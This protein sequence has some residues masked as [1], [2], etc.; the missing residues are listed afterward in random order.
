MQM[1]KPQ[2]QRLATIGFVLLL[3]GIMLD[4]LAIRVPVAALPLAFASLCAL[5]GSVVV[6]I[7]AMA[8]RQPSSNRIKAIAIGVIVFAAGF[9][10]MPLLTILHIW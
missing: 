5:L 1:N 10:L 3:L 8:K 9:L 4:R 2:V 6:L 7:V